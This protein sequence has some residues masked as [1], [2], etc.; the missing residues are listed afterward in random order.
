LAHDSVEER[1]QEFSPG[2]P[3]FFFSVCFVFF[4]EFFGSEKVLGFERG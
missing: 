4:W 1:A 2:K 3:G